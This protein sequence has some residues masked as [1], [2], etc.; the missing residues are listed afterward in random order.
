M[1]D[2]LTAKVLIACALSAAVIVLV[3]LAMLLAAEWMDS[4]LSGDVP[5]DVDG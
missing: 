5:E 2:P 3:A 1:M 4:Y